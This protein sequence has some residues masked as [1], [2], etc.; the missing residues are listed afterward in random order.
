VGASSGPADLTIGELAGL[1]GVPPATLRVWERRHGFPRAQR[2]ARGHRRY[3]HSEA[4]LVAEVARLKGQGVRL[5]RA[6]AQVLAAEEPVP[7]V[8]ATLRNRLPRTTAHRLRKASL[9]A[10]CHAIEDE[11]AARAEPAW[12]F[13]G[14]QE[15]RFFRASERRWADLARPA[16][17]AWAM[18]CFSTTQTV[19]SGVRLVRLDPAASM[20]REWALVW[21][22]DSRP[23]ALA[24]WELPGQP[25]RPDRD[26]RFETLW[27][28]DP[29]AVHDAAQTCV[30]LAERAG[31]DLAA[32]RSHLRRPTPA[33]ERLEDAT[34]LFA[35]VVAYLDGS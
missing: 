33:G 29:A 7:S 8:F 19:L 28:L 34:A 2:Q 22:A 12:L 32:V 35:R 26:R 14:F 18:A 3:L 31:C 4:D 23:V 21:L 16:R 10:L 6:V 30:A 20:R 13:G 5:D 27:T 24:A 9:V 25:P 15:E 11:C 17:G 1:T